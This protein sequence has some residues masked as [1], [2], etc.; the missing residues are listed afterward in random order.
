MITINKEDYARAQKF[1]AKKVYYVPG[2]GIDTKKFAVDPETK[3]VKRAAIRT[4]LGIP[5]D[6]IVLLS[7]GE[8]NEN[9]NH[10]VVIEALSK[11]EEK[12]VHYFLYRN[13]FKFSTTCRCFITP[14]WRVWQKGLFECSRNDE[15]SLGSCRHI[16]SSGS[17]ARFAVLY[18]SEE[19]MI[20]APAA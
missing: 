11:L 19:L 20:F 9:K 10:R 5:D 17:E 18:C 6:A 4:E 14:S 15:G 1:A 16:F 13:A 3:R 7:V 8:V 12:N 2:V